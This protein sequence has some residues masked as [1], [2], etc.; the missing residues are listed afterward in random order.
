MQRCSHYLWWPFAIA[1]VVLCEMMCCMSYSF[2]L[3]TQ[4]VKIVNSWVYMHNV[5]CPLIFAQNSCIIFAAWY[6][7]VRMQT[8]ILTN[9]YIHNQRYLSVWYFHAN[10][11]FFCCQEKQYCTI[12][13]APLRMQILYVIH[14]LLLYCTY[15]I[16]TKILCSHTYLIRPHCGSRS[17]TQIPSNGQVITSW[18]LHERPVAPFTNMV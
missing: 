10:R 2:T 15:L 16:L 7:R 8:S 18:R 11:K 5:S 9:I 4:K 14:E 12:Y 13:M 6:F 17:P 1:V 3:Y